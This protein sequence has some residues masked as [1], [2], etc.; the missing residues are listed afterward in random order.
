MLTHEDIAILTRPFP[1]ESHKF[2]KRGFC[3]V[4]EQFVT[5]RIEEVDP[6]WCFEIISE[7]RAG[8]NDQFAVVTARLMIKG[9]YRTSTG[10]QMVEYENA[11][12]DKGKVTGKTD[13]EAGEAEKGAT[14]DALRRAARLFGICRYIL[15]MGDSVK[16]MTALDNWLKERYASRQPGWWQAVGKKL[17]DHP[18]FEGVSAHMTNA[19]KRLLADNLV[20]PTMNEDDVLKVVY[21]KYPLP[22]N[23]QRR[24]S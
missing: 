3:Y 19:L 17:L 8:T 12:D 7:H 22:T 23:N 4:R 6:A 21:A 24:I 9:V 10:M 1:L 5:A 20:T 14:T 2:N 11:K 16:D 15:E 13:K 18:H